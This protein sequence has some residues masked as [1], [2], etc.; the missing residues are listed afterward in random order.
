VSAARIRFTPG[1]LLEAADLRDDAAT[2]ARLRSEHIR[3]V[4]ETWGVALGYSVGI[5]GRTVVVGPG[6]AYDCR[7]RAI[8]LSATRLLRVPRESLETHLVDLAITWAADVGGGEAALCA[9]PNRERP[10]FVWG[11]VASEDAPPALSLRIG[12]S[13]PLARFHIETPPSADLRIRRAAHTDA[14]PHIASGAVE[15]HVEGFTDLLETVVPVDTTAARFRTTPVYHAT[16]TG[17]AASLHGPMVSI[18]NAD[19][20]GFE[21][22]VRHGADAGLSYV[23][24]EAPHLVLEWL[25]VEIPTGSW[26]AADPV[27]VARAA[28]ANQATL[29]RFEALTLLPHVDDPSPPE[30]T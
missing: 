6:V 21:A 4:H 26:P 12:E 18:G 13:V 5:V 1:A 30:E 27:S 10:A 3:F 25:G 22:T 29:D 23:A 17:D 8:V 15:L 11:A 9:P 7:G 14:R 24:D 28:G 19:R 2:R 20:N 16:I